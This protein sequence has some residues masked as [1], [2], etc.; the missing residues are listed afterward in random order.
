MK[1]A[2]FQR[3][4]ILFD[5]DLSAG[6][7]DET[8]T[9]GRAFRLSEILFHFD[10][11]S[12][13]TI[14]ITKISAQGATYNTIKVKRSIVALQDFVYRPQGDADYQAGDEIQVECTNAGLTHVYVTIKTSEL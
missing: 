10:G 12:T 7:L 4:D 8:T 9:I 3:P 14:T 6:A 2:Y 1:T 5:K 11:A 13:E